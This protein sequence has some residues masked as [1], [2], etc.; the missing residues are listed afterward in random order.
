MRTRSF[1]ALVSIA[2]PAVIVVAGLWISSL[3]VRADDDGNNNDSKIQQGFRIAP[4]P[5]NLAGKSRQLVG[6]GSYLVNAVADC[7][8]CHGIGPPF[9]TAFLPGYNP[10]HGGTKI[11]NP[12]TYLGGGRDFG[13]LGPGSAHIISRN[14]TPDRTGRPEGGH[15]LAEFLLI[16]KTGTDLD[17]LHPTCSGAANPGCVPPPYDGAL[18]QIMPWPSFQDMTDHDL[19]AI[20]EYLSAIPCIAGPPA[21]SPLHND[22]S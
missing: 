2:S 1:R 5:L 16:M 10:F 18:L 7:N 22:C 12:A 14:L 20:Y 4:V 19:Q 11:V 21:P 8:A 15:T 17:H 3:R 6:L 9:L 13:P